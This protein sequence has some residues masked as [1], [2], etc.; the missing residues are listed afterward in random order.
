[1]TVGCQM[2]TSLLFPQL[3]TRSVYRQWPKVKQP[4]TFASIKCC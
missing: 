1:M 4:N 2:Q 3:K